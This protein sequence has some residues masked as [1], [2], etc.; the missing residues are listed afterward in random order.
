MASVSPT[1]RTAP[2]L[3]GIA[4]LCE[5]GAGADVTIVCG[6]RSWKMHSF[7][8]TVQC[9]FFEKALNGRFRE[10]HDKRID[11]SEDDES[12]LAAML[13]Y[14][15]HGDYKEAISKPADLL[16]LVFHTGIYIVANKYDI[17]SLASLALESFEASFRAE[18]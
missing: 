7:A 5:S 11:L 2:L 10:S 8:L 16:S 9:E 13:Y 18:W 1:P 3:Q 17:E 15:Y 6:G 12:A 4:R 14:L